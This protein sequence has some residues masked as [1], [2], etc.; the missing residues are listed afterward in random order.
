MLSVTTD[1]V[2]S[3]GDPSPYLRR[4]AD[5]GFTHLHWCHQW[6]TDFLYSKWEV[7]QIERWLKEFGLQLLDLHAS[8]GPEKNWYSEQEYERLSGVELVQ[9]RIDVTSRLGGEVIIM[10]IPKDPECAP[11]RKSLDALEPYARDHGVRIAV[12]NGD[13]TVIRRLLSEY[14]PGFLGTCYDS[15]HGNMA[16]D[17]LDNLDDC[18]DR[19]ISLH[20]N[21]ND[22]TGDQHQPIFMGTVDWE[23]LAGII[24]GSSYR[25]CV[26]M[27]IVTRNSGIEDETEF[28]K[29]AFETGTRFTKMIDRHR[30]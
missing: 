29:H 6:N 14:D 20:M 10:H 26:S 2:T 19:L 13:Y 9:N 7:D 4:I 25:K 18:K 21:D 27:E 28:L 11:L 16:G 23:R 24:G 22:S 30:G 5:A 3:K 15:G 8:V 17:G 1:Y 12:E